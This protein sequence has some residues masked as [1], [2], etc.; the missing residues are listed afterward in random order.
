MMAIMITMLLKIY[1]ASS[2]WIAVFTVQRAALV[3]EGQGN[4]AFCSRFTVAMRL[5]GLVPCLK[6]QQYQ[7][8]SSTWQMMVII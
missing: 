1:L 7:L 2:R 4:G 5:Q 6:A 8:S 3:L